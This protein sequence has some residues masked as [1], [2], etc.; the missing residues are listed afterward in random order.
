[1]SV[2]SSGADLVREL[3]A[4]EGTRDGAN[5]PPPNESTDSAAKPRRFRRSRELAALIV[6]RMNDP[7]TELRFGDQVI[8]RAIVGSIITLVGGTGSGKTSA[9]LTFA[10]EH[11]RRGDPVVMMSL[12]L[13]AHHAAARAVGIQAHK[14]WESALRGEV[15]EEHMYALLPDELAIVDRR[16]ADMDALHEA[17]AA[18]V[19]DYLG[20]PVLAIVDYLQIIGDAEDQRLRVS[21]AMEA[22]ASYAHDYPVLVLALSQSSRAGAHALG[23]GE[24]IGNEIVDTGA[25]SAAIERWSTFKLGI[26]KQGEPDEFGS[27]NVQLSIAKGRMSGADAVINCRYHAVTGRWEAV[28]EARRASEVRA[29]AAISGDATT[30]QRL[31]ILIDAALERALEPMSRNKIH[32]A[33]A[34]KKGFVLAEISAMLADPTSG[35]VEV[36]PKVRGAFQLWKRHHAERVGHR[37]VEPQPE[38]VSPTDPTG[39][40]ECQLEPVPPTDPTDPTGSKECQP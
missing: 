32:T 29:E 5:P 21:D 20:R 6:E 38:P 24:K 18:M 17:T 39:S 26:G 35:V 4:H 8:V 7:W 10:V 25:E 19:A 16:D 40:K 14:S 11:M 3:V 22:L 13:P 31:R 36:H 37:I 2:P 33:C 34:G 1:M 30:R 28:G 23:S 12:E 27:R 9:A 15:S